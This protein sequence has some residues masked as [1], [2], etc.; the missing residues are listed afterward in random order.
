MTVNKLEVRHET[1]EEGIH[2]Y[3]LTGS[4]FGTTG[5]YAFVDE[6]RE[7]SSSGAK[8]IIVDFS[9]VDRID[10]CGIGI[11]VST[12]WSASEAGC[13]MVLA[14]I[15]DR[16]ER[17]LTMAM[18]LDHIGHADTVEAALETIKTGNDKAAE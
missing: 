14:A 10:S 13:E 6:I 8:G 9:G 3:A 16:I 4:L 1:P 11:I 17:V 7:K 15:P 5:G 18:L 12:I 2:I